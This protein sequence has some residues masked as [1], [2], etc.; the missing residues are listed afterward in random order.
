MSDFIGTR[1][2]AIC[3]I[4]LSKFNPTRGLPLFKP[5]F[6]GDKYETLDFIVELVNSDER[7]YFFFVQV[8]ATTQGY[9]KRERRLQARL[10]K[11][12]AVKLASYPAPTYVVGI[13]EHNESGYIT[14]ISRS[15]PKGIPS[16][17]TQFPINHQ[18]LELLWTEV[19]EQWQKNNHGG[20]FTSQFCE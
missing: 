10:T 8:K 12:D 18:N 2:E 6:L 20:T 1:G 3:F 7:T 11:N 4:L 13:D 15:A 17:S 9:T 14:T 19:R 16:I 5:Q